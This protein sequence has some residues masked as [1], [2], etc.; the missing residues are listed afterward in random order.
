MLL[1]QFVGPGA[2]RAPRGG[3][4]KLPMDEASRMDRARAMGYA[5]EPFWRGEKS[6]SAPKLGEP[7]HFARDR[8]TAAGF[9]AQ[10]GGE[11][12]EFRLRLD[13]DATLSNARPV[14]A[15]QFQRVL[16][17]LHQDNPKAALDLADMVAT[18]R[19]LDWWRVFAQR[20]PDHPVFEAPHLRQIIEIGRAHV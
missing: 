7:A 13:P 5:D 4:K 19:N 8:E 6:G 12:R 3:F 11:P 1:S 14:T 10:G 20:M 15:R 2:V 16:D 9:A 17:A 18:G